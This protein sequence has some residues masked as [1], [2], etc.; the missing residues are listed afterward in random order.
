MTNVKNALEIAILLC[1]G[2]AFGFF[3]ARELIA[4]DCHKNGQFAYAHFSY[5]CKLYAEKKK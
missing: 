1:I 5:E 2:A 4:T 3:Y